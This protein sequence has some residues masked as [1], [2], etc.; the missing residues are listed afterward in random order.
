MK[1]RK[2]KLNYVPQI[3]SLQQRDQEGAISYASAIDN[4][5]TQL[6]QIKIKTLD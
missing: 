4:S 2:R 6:N 5:I 3:I 1:F